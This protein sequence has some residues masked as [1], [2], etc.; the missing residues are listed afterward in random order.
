MNMKT[1]LEDMNKCQGCR[2][3][4]LVCPVRCIRIIRDEEGFQYPQIDA[5]QCLECGLCSEICKSSRET[6]GQNQK[7]YAMYNN[8]ESIRKASSSGGIFY[9]LAK[10]VIE[11]E[12]IVSG[13]EFDEKL[14]AKHTLIDRIEDIPKLMGSKYVQSD[15]EDIYASVKKVLMTNK[16][17]LFTGTPCQIRGLYRYLQKDYSNLITCAIVCH[18]VPSPDIWKRYIKMKEGICGQ[19]IRIVDFRNKQYEGWKNFHVNYKY[20]DITEEN[21]YQ[22]DVYFRGF[23]E[24]LYLRPSCYTCEGDWKMC[25]ADLIIGD[26]WGVENICPEV[27]GYNGISLVITNSS[28]G[29]NLVKGIQNQVYRK[30]IPLEQALYYNPPLKY[31]SMSNNKRSKF[32]KELSETGNLLDAI[33]I[34][35]RREPTLEKRML[36]WAPIWKKYIRAILSGATIGNKLKKMNYN[37]IG[38][39][40]VTDITELVIM[41]LYQNGYTKNEIKL[42]DKKSNKISVGGDIISSDIPEVLLEMYST[43][44]IEAIIICS[45][46]YENEIMLWM[47]ANNINMENVYGIDEIISY[48]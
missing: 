20:E 47:K 7:V 41:D 3:C 2:A 39:Y 10:W 18:G 21:R 8:D 6:Q 27:N 4:E 13:V 40:A 48:L 33:H 30:S 9:L 35:L 1:V 12:G 19:A 36:D 26:L 24:N 16:W 25:E 38:V 46:T 45:M 31:A 17:V 44:K 11:Q 37:K 14:Y 22:D 34:N 32:Y 5:E 15:T 42:F 43:A 23:L 29:E 28:K